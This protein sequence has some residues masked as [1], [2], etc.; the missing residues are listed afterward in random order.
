MIPK[1]CVLFIEKEF[2]EVNLFRF[3]EYLNGFSEGALGGRAFTEQSM[4]GTD[5][6]EIGSETLSGIQDERRLET[7]R[8]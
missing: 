4:S 5:Y 3:R 8:N 1:N 6:E 7:S 2:Q